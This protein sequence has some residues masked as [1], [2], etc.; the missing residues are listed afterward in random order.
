MSHLGGCLGFWLWALV[1]MGMTLGFISFWFAIP[2]ALLVGYLI[3]RRAQWNDGPV[4]LGLIAGAGLCFLLVAAINWSDWHHRTPGN[5]YPSPYTWG[6]VGL[7]LIIAAV[8]A[9]AIRRGRST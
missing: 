6:G 9:Y 7:G 4:Q 8:I 2:P 3:G 5:E 1:G